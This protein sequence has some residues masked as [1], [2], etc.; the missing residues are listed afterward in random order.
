MSL[1]GVA[2]R[3]L[4]VA[5][6]VFEDGRADEFCRAVMDW[7]LRGIYVSSTGGTCKALLTDWYDRHVRLFT[8]DLSTQGQ[9][10]LIQNK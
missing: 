2:L 8:D 10:H 4:R 1:L 9:H 7:L 5:F 6:L 3:W